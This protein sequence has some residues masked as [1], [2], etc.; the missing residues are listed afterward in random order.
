[1]RNLKYLIKNVK[2]FHTV[3]FSFW[4]CCLAFEAGFLVAQAGCSLRMNLNF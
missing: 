4:F 3:F 1:M 2:D